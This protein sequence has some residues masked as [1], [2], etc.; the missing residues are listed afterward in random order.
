M[1]FLEIVVRAK[2][3]LARHHRVSLRALRRE[4][5]LDDQG[6]EELVEELVQVQQVA[7]LDGRTL[8][9]TQ[10]TASPEAVETPGTPVLAVPEAERRQLTVMFCDLVGS[11][12]L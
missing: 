3:Y 4:F 5:D 6:V 8:G 12:D 10:R 2:A 1:S 11:T 7:V 9:W